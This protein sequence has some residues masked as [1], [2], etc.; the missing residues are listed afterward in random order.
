VGTLVLASYIG[1]DASGATKAL[2]QANGAYVAVGAG[3]TTLQNAYDNGDTIITAGGDN[4]YITG[5][6][7]LEVDASGGIIANKLDLSETLDVSGD[8]TFLS[9]LDASGAYFAADISGQG[10]QFAGL[11]DASAA[12][13]RND[14]DVSG[15]LSVV[16]LADF[17]G[18]TFSADISGVGAYFSE[19]VQIDALLDASAILVRNDLD[20]SGNADVS[21]NFS[22]IGTSDFSGAMTAG[23]ISGANLDLSATLSVAGLADF[24]GATFSADIS[25]VSAYFSTDMD[26]SGNLAVDGMAQFKEEVGT[27][28]HNYT[29]S[30]I[31]A[32]DICASVGGARSIKPALADDAA[33]A[34]EW[35]V[36]AVAV[37]QINAGADG[38]VASVPGTYCTINL[39]SGQTGTAGDPVYLSAAQAGKAT[40]TP[41]SAAGNAISQVGYLAANIADAASAEIV[42]A[43]QFMA[44][45]PA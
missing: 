4:V 30:A 18:A 33:P 40:L 21:G 16:G 41:P 8:V 15:T 22:V 19:G 12:L 38:F 25:G 29:G 2:F 32:G 39:A 45:I 1:A 42:L 37:A 5:T 23:D 24:S 13:I 26:I 28:A 3:S 34:R 27:I 9:H 10:A 6:E 35:R 31:A 44:S 14:L 11:L 43:P 7:A 20:V 36:Y 17:S